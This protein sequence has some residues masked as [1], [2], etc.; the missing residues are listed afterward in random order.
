MS[1]ERWAI[2]KDVSKKLEETGYRVI[3]KRYREPETS[4]EKREWYPKGKKYRQNPLDCYDLIETIQGMDLLHI[5]FVPVRSNGVA[6]RNECIISLT[7]K[8]LKGSMLTSEVI[9][10]NVNRVKE[11]AQH[12]NV[13][14]IVDMADQ[15]ERIASEEQRRKK[16]PN[17]KEQIRYLE[18]KYH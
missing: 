1:D 18:R 10:T 11:I 2:A 15:K 6:V 8:S 5:T 3:R 7:A 4:L 12:I 16:E 9:E 13:S 17:P 14:G